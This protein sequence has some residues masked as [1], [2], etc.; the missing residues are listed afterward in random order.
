MTISKFLA[1]TALS[2]SIA[3]CASIPVTKVSVQSFELQKAGLTQTAAVAQ[4]TGAFVDK[5]FDV[6]MSNADAGV[7]TTE[8]KKF[9]SVSSDPPFDYYMQL[10]AKVKLVKGISSVQIVPAIREQNRQ[11]AAAFTE[12]ELVYFTGDPENVAEIAS[13]N[14]AAGWRSSAQ[15]LFVNAVLGVAEA[16]GVNA[17]SIIQ[18][19]S[20]SLSNARDFED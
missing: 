7:V 2:F 5:G 19:V 20:K 8:Y 9:A 3:A 16:L 10:R 1:V 12:R 18:N 11:N 6:K 14:T 13:M 15:T 17:D 4:L